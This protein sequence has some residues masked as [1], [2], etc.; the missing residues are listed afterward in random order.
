MTA[1]NS[2][3]K[4]EEEEEAE[5]AEEAEVPITRTNIIHWSF[6]V[7]GVDTRHCHTE[8]EVE[9]VHFRV[10]GQRQTIRVQTAMSL[11]GCVQHYCITSNASYSESPTE[12]L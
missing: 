9:I 10:I 1:E 5:E 6:F 12:P 7:L 8:Q 4:E 2:P 3:E 11:N